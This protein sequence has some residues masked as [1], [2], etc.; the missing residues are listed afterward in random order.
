MTPFGEL[1]QRIMKLGEERRCSMIPLRQELKSFCRACELLLSANLEPR[2]NEEEQE[3][4]TYYVY[5][6]VEKFG[7]K[8]I[9]SM[10]KVTDVTPTREEE[11]S[12]RSSPSD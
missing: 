7:H 6:L 4:I 12:V 5:E 9:N 10:T 2:L 3:L 1:A 11:T 8:A